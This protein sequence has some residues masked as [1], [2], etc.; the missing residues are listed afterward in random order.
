MNHPKAIRTLLDISLLAGEAILNIYNSPDALA[1]QSKEDG[2][3]LTLADLASNKVIIEHL[4]KNW[5]EIPIIS[6]EGKSLSYEKR[7]S[8]NQFW[9]VDPLD[10]TKEFIKRNGEFT[11]NIALIENGLPVLGVVHAPALKLTYYGSSQLGSFKMKGSEAIQIFSQEKDPMTGLKIVESRSH[12]VELPESLL[13]KIKITERVPSGSSIK[14]CLVA[15]GSADIY[16]RLA[17]TMEWDVAAGDAVYR[18]SGKNSPRK[19]NLTYNKETLKNDS[20]ILGL[21]EGVWNADH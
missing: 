2:S 19:S 10:G 15:D 21:K 14:L 20:F 11:T 9:L 7:K 18:F 1:N 12:S 17:P 13:S 5:P 16:P 8:W 4:K 6:E 3:P